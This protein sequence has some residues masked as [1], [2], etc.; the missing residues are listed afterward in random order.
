MSTPS[1][2]SVRVSTHEHCQSY[3]TRTLQSCSSLSGHFISFSCPGEYP[4]S[5]DNGSCIRPIPLSSG[6][7]INTVHCRAEISFKLTWNQTKSERYR[8]LFVLLLA[9]RLVRSVD[10]LT[11]CFNIDDVIGLQLKC[12]NLIMLRS[13][14]SQSDAM[15]RR[16]YVL[17]SCGDSRLHWFNV[18]QSET[19]DVISFSRRPPTDWS[20]ARNNHFDFIICLLAPTTRQTSHRPARRAAPPHCH[21]VSV[22]FESIETII[23]ISAKQRR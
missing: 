15:K 20:L 14:Q 4:Y 19:A 6:T 1:Y 12:S 11:R 5:S 17:P 18:T 8:L 7:L 22:P 3:L 2:S 10:T 23:S 9:S 13:S 16:V 21:H